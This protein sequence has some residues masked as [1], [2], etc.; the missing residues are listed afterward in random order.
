MPAAWAGVT[1]AWR[2]V[3]SLITS[4]ST[5]PMPAITT[6]PNT[7]SWLTPSTNSAS[8]G[9]IFCTMMPSMR[10]SGTLRFT[11][12]WIAV[13]ASRTAA[14]SARP[15]FTPRT[16]VLCRMSGDSI[17]IATGQPSAC[18]AS[19]ACSTV[20]ASRTGA[21][22]MPASASRAA[23]SSVV[24][25][26]FDP[27]SWSSV[28]STMASRASRSASQ[29]RRASL[30]CTSPASASTDGSAIRITGMPAARSASSA[31]SGMLTQHTTS[32]LSYFAL[33]A[34]KM[35]TFICHSFSVSDSHM[36]ATCTFGSSITISM[37]FWISV[38]STSPC[39]VTSTGLPIDPNTGTTSFSRARV[40]GVN[41]AISMPSSPAR[42]AMITP[43]PPDR[44]MTAMPLPCAGSQQDSTST[45]SSSCSSLRTR[46]S[47][48]CRA[49]PS[50]TASAPA[51]APV[52]DAAARAPA[53]VRP[54]LIATSGLPLSIAKRAVSM[55]RSPLRSPSM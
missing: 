53:A 2:K 35:S 48:Y 19:T 34:L 17:F 23:P 12:A 8:P 11:L 18:A 10:A 38:G 33:I 40:S 45:M 5:P 46:S 41:W 47:P 6:G 52:W 49:T 51:S 42:S 29:R 16:S 44:V 7:G 25:A 26:R 3:T 39:A 27:T 50:N 43:A 36:I 14:S 54:T 9:I 32:G 21:A 24:S 37:L 20:V 55:N 28:G 13:Q 22:S 30:K 1:G 15:S 4:T 31:G